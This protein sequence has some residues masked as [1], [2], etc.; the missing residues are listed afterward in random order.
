M[1]SEGHKERKGQGREWSGKMEEKE[2]QG[3]VQKE[4]GKGR[5]GG[6]GGGPLSSHCVPLP[7]SASVTSP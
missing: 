2:T 4:G 3:G 5:E 7:Y 1:G 6:R